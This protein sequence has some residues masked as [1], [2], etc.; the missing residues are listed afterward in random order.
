MSRSILTA[1]LL[2]LGISLSLSAQPGSILKDTIGTGI[3]EDS[4]NNLRSYPE[5]DTYYYPIMVTGIPTTATHQ[6]YTNTVNTTEYGNCYMGQNTNDVYYCFTLPKEM[7][8]TI[9]HNY[10]NLTNTCL[11][12]LNSTQQLL[13]ANDDYYGEG[14]CNFPTQAYIH[15]SL[16]SGT[17]FVVSEGKDINGYITTNMTFDEIPAGDTGTNPIVCGSYSDSFSFIDT[18][19]TAGYS[20]RMGLE[21][22]DVYYRFS[23]SVPMNV[24]ITNEHSSVQDTYL[25]LLDSSG[26]VITSNDNYHGESHC[27]DTCLAFMNRQLPAGAYY[28]VAEGKVLDGNITTNITG[29]TSGSYAYSS[30]PSSYSTDPGTAVGG[31]GTTFGVSPTGGASISVPIEVPVGVSGMQPQLAIVYNS[32]SGNGLCGYGAGLS[33]ISSITRGPKDIYHDGTAQA[34]TYLADDALYL[35]GVRLIL[36]SGTAGQ[37]SAIY[38]PESDPFTRVI[39]HETC[40][41]T[42]NSTWFEV[43]SSDGMVY[44]YGRNQ[45]SRLSYTAGNSQRIH[46]WYVCRAQQPTGNYMTWEYQQADYCVYPSMISYGTNTDFTSTLTN[47]IEFTYES[48]ND[49]VPIRFDGKQGSM[50][51]RL[52]TITGSTN[53][54]TYRSYTLNYNTTGDGTAYKFSRLASV[55]EKNGQNESLPSTQLSWSYLPSVSYLSNDV[56]VSQPN[57]PNPFASFPM[58]SQSFLSGDL[59]GDG[60]SDIVGIGSAEVPNNQGGSDYYTYVHF[61]YASYSSTGALQYLSGYN[62]ELPPTVAMGRIKG[63][64]N[65]MSVIDVDGDGINE[66]ILPYFVSNSYNSALG[67]YAL[68]QNFPVYNEAGATSLHGNSEPLFISGDIDNDGRTDVAFIETFQYN[69]AYPIYIWK[70]NTDYIPGSNDVSHAL[71]DMDIEFSLSLGSQ[72]RNAMIA[73]MNGN[74]LN[75]L[76]VICDERYTVYLNQGGGLSSSTFSDSYRYTSQDMTN[77]DILTFGDFNGDGL[78]DILTKESWNWYFYLNSGDGNF[79]KSLC[80]S[81]GYNVISNN[82]HC[83]IIDFDGDGRSD[84]VLTETSHL[85]GM[86]SAPFEKTHTRWLRSTGTTLIQENYAT[87]LRQ[88]DALSSRYI[89][90]DFDGDG[91]VELANYGYDCVNG[92]DADTDPSW[93]IYKNSGLTAQTGKVTSVTSDFGATTGITYSTLSDSSVYNRGTAEPYP[94][95]RYTIP[96]N[97]VKET[98]ESN[99]AAGNLV[100]Q[101][102]YEGLKAHLKG[103]GLLG[104]SKTTAN[105]ITTGVQMQSGI[106]QWDTVHYM[107]RLTY[108][109]TSIGTSAATTTNTLSIEDTYISNH[110]VY[111]AYPSQTVSTDMDGHTTTAYYSYNTQKGYITSDS[112]VYDAGMYRT[113]NYL[114]YTAEK[115]G[116]VYRPQTVVQSQRH[117]DDSSPFSRTTTY[118]YNSTTGAV[119]GMTENHGTSKPLTTSYTYDVWGNVTSQ[120]VSAG[121][122]T[123]LTTYYSYDATHRFPVRIYTSPWSSVQQYTYDVWGNVLTECDSINSSINNTIT[124]TYDSWGK[125]VST[126]IPGSGEITYTYGWSSDASQRWFVLEQGTARPWVKTWYDNRGR[127][128]RTESVGPKDVKQSSTRTYDSNGLVTGRTDVNGNLTLSYNYTYDERGRIST[129]ESPGGHTV[130]YQYGNDRSITIT[131]NGENGLISATKTFDAWGNLKTLTA[132]VSGLTNTYASNGGIKTTESGGATWTFGY[133]DR[134]NR[135]SLVDPDAGTTTY[136]YDALGRETSRTDGRGVVY[137][138]NYDYLGRVTSR[139]AGYDV[140]YYTYGTS[141]TGQM[142]VTKESNDSWTKSYSYDTYGRITSE[143]MSMNYTE[144]N[145]TKTYQ[146]N[147]AGLLSGRGYPGDRTLGYLYDAYGNCT[148]ISSDIPFFEW[149]LT[150]YNGATTTST[151]SLSN[152]TSYYRTT[153][154]DIYGQLQSRVTRRAGNN[155]QADTYTFNPQTGNLTSRTVNGV[156]QSFGYD[157]VNRLTSVTTGLNNQVCMTYAAN[158]N[159]TTKGDIGQFTYS[160]TTRPHAVTAVDFTGSIPDR[161]QWLYYNEWGKIEELSSIDGDDYCYYEVEYGPDQERVFS[162]LAKNNDAPRYKI[163]WG[164]YEE[165]HVGDTTTAFYWIDAP[166]GLAGVIRYSSDDF[167]H[168]WHSFAATTDHLGSLTALYDDSR[169][170]VHEASYDAWGKRTLGQVSMPLVTRGYTGHEH[171]DELGLINMNGRLY[172]FNIGRFLSPDIFVQSPSNPQNYNRYSYCLNNPLKYTDPDGESVIALVGAILLA[173]GWTNV[174]IQHFNGS[175]HSVGD[176]FSAFVGGVAAGVSEATSWA[177]AFAELSTGSPLGVLLGLSILHGKSISST[178]TLVNSILHPINATKLFLGRYYTDENQNVWNQALQGLSRFTWEGPQTWAG[179]NWSNIRSIARKVDKIDYLG[180]A[181]FCINKD[182]TYGSVSLGNYINADIDGSYNGKITDYPVLMHE[183]GHTFDSRKYGPAYLFEIGIPSA[184]SASNSERTEANGITTT[185]HKL[186][187]TEQRASLNA[188]YYFNKNYGVKITDFELYLPYHQPEK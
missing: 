102:S 106:T 29:Y 109:T 155:L 54:N 49:S 7:I 45:D 97:V 23:L 31:M 115:V 42:S 146:Y 25:Y 160:S 159:I 46:S 142:R 62:Y 168:P 74:G 154:L 176:F 9:T 65:A 59:N 162:L 133:D 188:Y 6:T 41:S 172:D 5:G 186:F 82:C 127:E 161:D 129:E 182:G 19:N 139:S 118:T 116:G 22:S 111:F 79:V 21:T 124:H 130:G 99:G 151:V 135:T 78:P 85:L 15:T 70:Y 26:S 187:W 66:L 165:Y 145:W 83:D 174:G 163:H 12:L 108:S 167:Y 44:W 81:S 77:H 38:I 136:V 157:N 184:I 138:T 123:I 24:T 134:G 100:T 143:T 1:P 152:N 75:D 40:T 137:V 64:I 14:Q 104:F 36:S 177:F 103:R 90:G 153:Q 39:A 114:D 48:R 150:G 55:T 149:T 158:G 53:G 69:N 8:V 183:Y 52:K 18:R 20:D 141:G 80:A 173:T 47:I 71:F 67:L 68:G 170:K 164:D 144:M 181:T 89:T 2:L 56:T 113:I 119:S 185:T 179:Y 35:D 34:M 43:Q 4:I 105:C 180:G 73:D 86:L 175:I 63:S 50:G 60:L 156:T 87:S 126:S 94:A 112:T 91:H 120:S 131:E 148:K 11:Y 88:A 28:V 61:Y 32:Q 107:P 17:Y 122:S 84:V 51:R 166:D 3:D 132:P 72:P 169:G 93:R 96:L 37:D 16:P 117:A 110:K 10:S 57:L 76:L 125:P 171:L 128:V 33:G 30:I 147:S 140:T 178:T 58:S 101:F 13:V 95:P 121:G 27:T 98:T 92:N